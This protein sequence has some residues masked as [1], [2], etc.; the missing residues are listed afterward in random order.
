MRTL[1]SL[2]IAICACVIAGCGAMI[3]K[4]NEDNA[5]LVGAVN[6]DTPTLIKSCQDRTL[7]IDGSKIS[8]VNFIINDSLTKCDAFMSGLVLT[9]NTVNTGFDMATGLLSALATVF[10]PLSTVLQAPDNSRGP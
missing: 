4:A 6:L 9:E 8:C 2:S 5:F 1:R 3:Q 10:I 7:I